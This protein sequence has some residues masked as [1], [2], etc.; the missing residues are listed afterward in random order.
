MTKQ[1]KKD[2]VTAMT[3]HRK[4]GKTVKD[5]SQRTVKL[6]NKRYG[7]SYT[8]NSITQIFYANRKTKTPVK[9]T[10]DNV[11]VNLYKTY[12]DAHAT[13]AKTL[14]TEFINNLVKNCKQIEVENV[15]DESGV[16]ILFK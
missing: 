12:R 6:M 2:I 13:A 14:Q 5:A 11:A 9:V 10:E 8:V 3:M 15:S 7:K 4:A 16:L 1:M